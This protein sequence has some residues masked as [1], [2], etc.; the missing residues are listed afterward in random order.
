MKCKAAI[1]A[2]AVGTFAGGCFTQE[3]SLLTSENAARAVPAI[4]QAAANDDRSALPRLV[5]DL[6]DPDSAIRFAAIT[7]LRQMTG[8]DFG[9]QYFDSEYNCQPAIAKWKAWLKDQGYH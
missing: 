8:Q 4:K 6:S 2:L 9:Y 7:A 5:Y 3:S 1:F